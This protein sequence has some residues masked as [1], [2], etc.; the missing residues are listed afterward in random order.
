[1][2]SVEDGVSVNFDA[3]WHG[4]SIPHKFVRTEKQAGG[5]TVGRGAKHKAAG[6]TK[7]ERLRST[8][9]II[10]LDVGSLGGDSPNVGDQVWQVCCS[11][12]QPCR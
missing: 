12:G 6:L 4:A 11:Q 2:S 3:G 8:G 1:M 7:G 5:Q 10:E 9:S